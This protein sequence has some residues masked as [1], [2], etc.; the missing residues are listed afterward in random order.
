MADEQKVSFGRPTGIRSTEPGVGRKILEFLTGYPTTPSRDPSILDLVMAAASI[1]PPTRGVRMLD[2]EHLKLLSKGEEASVAARLLKDPQ[3]LARQRARIEAGFTTPGWHGTTVEQDFTE[4][5]DPIVTHPLK[6]SDFGIHVASQPATAEK[7]LRGLGSGGPLKNARI[8][9]VWARV[10]KA[11]HMPDMSLWKDPGHWVN[12]LADP[13]AAAM[14]GELSLN[15]TV[16]TSDP[17][18]LKALMAMAI[19]EGSREGPP[20]IRFQQK[21][22]DMLRR[23]GYDTI[24]YPNYLEGTGDISYLL[25]DPRQ[26]RSIFAQFDKPAEFK[27]LRDLFSGVSGLGKEMK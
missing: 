11:L 5:M 1:F 26:L 19:E 18:M 9:P 2:P 23:G 21:V 3:E 24:A 14:R 20:N 17:D 10:Q 16:Q 27:K 15:P 7:A 12:Q 8:L 22:I 4:F 6:G 25:T 13:T